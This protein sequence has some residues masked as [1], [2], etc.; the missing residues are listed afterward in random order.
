LKQKNYIIYY[1]VFSIIA[2]I[3]LLI[4]AVFANSNATFSFHD[5]LI[6][7]ASL[8]VSFLFGISLAKYPGWSR[9][10]TNHGERDSVS[11]KQTKTTT[12]KF[13]GHHPDCE[14]FN[15]H[16]LKTKNRTYCAGCLGLLVGSII[17]IILL[18][19]YIIL[20]VQS[21]APYYLLLIIGITIL[22]LSLIEILLP[23]R[24]SIV[25]IIS[26][27]FLVISFLIITIS[28]LEIT[29]DK[30]FGIIVVLFSF[31]WLDTRI[32]LSKWRHTLM[33]INC[34]EPCKMY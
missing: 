34:N 16:I 26:N 17:S 20:P 7:G 15:T 21:F 6:V 28:I 3:L 24:N 4:L 18:V 30:L 1:L 8:L 14:K 27:I 10:L 2:V 19:I 22:G 9:K 33:C 13:K 25:H 5:K 31:L 29:G 32:Q 12:K 11:R 23:I